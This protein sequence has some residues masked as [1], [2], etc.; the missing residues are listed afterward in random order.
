MEKLKNFI[1]KIQAYIEN[2]LQKDKLEHFFIGSILGYGLA[3]MFKL[4]L[5]AKIW[6]P[7]ILIT[8]AILKEVVDRY[9]RNGKFD[10][11]DILF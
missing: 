9:I 6:I 5:L 3:T 4:G 1:N 2:L 10:L 11:L 8:I 7:I